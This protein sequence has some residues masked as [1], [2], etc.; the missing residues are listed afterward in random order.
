MTCTYTKAR[1]EKH[2]SD[3]FHIQDILIWEDA[4]LSL[5][6]NFPLVCVCHSEGPNQPRWTEIEWDTLAASQCLRCSF[7][8]GRH[9]WSIKKKVVIVPWK[10]E[11]FAVNN[12]KIKCMVKSWEHNM[13][14][15]YNKQM[16][17]KSFEEET[18]FKNLGKIPTKK[19]CICTEYKCRLNSWNIC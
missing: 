4:L 7:N 19:Y 18:R 15:N 11:N 2:L 8:G 5:L 6:F 17:N 14:H 16:G 13:G 3:K 12:E 10:E 9:V 1:E